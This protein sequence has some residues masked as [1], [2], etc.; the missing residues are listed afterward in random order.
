MTRG[1]EKLGATVARV[2]PG[3]EA[4]VLAEHDVVGEALRQPGAIL[5][6]GERLAT[7]P[8]GLSAAAALADR[9]GA[10]LAWVPRRAGDRGAVDAGCLPNLLPG[11]RLGHRRGRPGRAGRRVGP[12]GRASSRPSR[13]AT[14]TRI[15]AAAAAGRLGALVVAG[16]DPADLA[17][18]RLAE[19]ALDKVPL[20]GQPRGAR[21]PR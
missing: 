1:L 13:A 18:P 2:V 17:D 11:G 3:E 10:K 19:Q 15:I 6:V 14:P 7:V 5:L 4:R 9:T 20:P 8:G 21:Q 16:V 12:R